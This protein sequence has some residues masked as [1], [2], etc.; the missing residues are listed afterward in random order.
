MMASEH[1]SSGP[2]LHAMTPATISSRLVPNPLPSTQFVPPSRTDWDLFFQPLFDEILNAPS[3]V[4]CQAPEVISPITKVVA[5]EPASSTGSPSTTTIDQDAPS[6]N[7]AHMNNDP[8]FGIPILENDPEASSSS[9][10]F[11]L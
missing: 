4:N 6:P 11:L 10:V 5:L 2:A 8:L 7:V 1:S 9:D 3:S